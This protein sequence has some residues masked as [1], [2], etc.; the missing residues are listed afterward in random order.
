MTESEIDLIKSAQANDTDAF[1]ALAECHWRRI[2]VLAFH[3]CHNS[4]DAEDL[5]QEVWLK[6]YQAL[7]TYRF[8][9]SFY[10]WLRRITINTFLNHQRSNLLRRPATQ[11]SQLSQIDEE[12]SNFV[13]E[14]TIYN[15]VLFE[16]VVSALTELTPAQRLM[17]L[18][19]HY[20]GMSYD[21]IAAAMNC[22]SGTAKKA[23]WRALAKLRVKLEVCDESSDDGIARL[24]A[25]C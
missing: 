18:L 4:Q 12:I 21:E 23:V 13:S 9:S 19:R 5:S 15:R 14:E 3:Y 24:A 17:F 11:V 7:R 8:D 10:T 25:E 1:C 20:E 22:S 2:Y 6:A 16:N